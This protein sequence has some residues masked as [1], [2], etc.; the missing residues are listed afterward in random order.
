[1]AA[2]T[3]QHRLRRASPQRGWGAAAASGVATVASVASR[4]ARG[5]DERLPSGAGRR[6]AAGI[7]ATVLCRGCRLA[8]R[9]AEPVSLAKSLWLHATDRHCMPRPRRGGPWCRSPPWSLPVT[10]PLLDL[11]RAEPLRPENR[12]SRR[13]PRGHGRGWE[14]YSESSACRDRRPGS[15]VL[16][17]MPALHAFIAP[18]PRR[19]NGRSGQAHWGSKPNFTST[20]RTE[21]AENG[22]RPRAA[23]PLTNEARNQ[24]EPPSERTKST[25]VAHAP[26]RTCKVSFRD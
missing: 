3:A 7:R 10:W 20:T 21:I 12:E 17:N 23:R 8:L 26:R 9:R 11:G 14:S 25:I 22:R 5:V 6:V 19:S 4:A 15:S 2:R 18:R 24:R 13:M 1:M 16:W